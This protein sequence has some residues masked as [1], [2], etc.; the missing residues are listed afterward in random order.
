MPTSLARAL[1][2]SGFAITAEVAPPH[3]CDCSAMLKAAGL[4]APHVDAINVTDNQGANMRMSSLAAAAL[5]VREGYEPVMQLTCRDRNR[6]ALQSELLG[7]AAFGVKNV[8]ALTGDDIGC[9]DHRHA[10][11]VFDVDSVMLLDAVK[12]LN[13]GSDMNGTPL[14]GPTS[15]FCG[16]AAAPEAEPF[17]ATLPKLARKAAAGAAFFQTQAVFRPEKLAVFCEAIRPLGVPVM[18][19]ILVLRSARMAEYINR[20]IPGLRI[21]DEVVERLRG[22]GRPADEGVRI[23]IE[24]ACHVRRVC[25]GVHIM[26]M[27]RDECVPEIV[28]AVR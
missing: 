15:F 26:T 21:P 22:A 23:A 4:L 13:S 2:D 10:R 17:A 3:G 24:M 7:A 8:L 20:N 12:R 1:A 16:A 5:L 27:G 18:G 11:A 19:G 25:S 28:A 9:G 14:D 6:M